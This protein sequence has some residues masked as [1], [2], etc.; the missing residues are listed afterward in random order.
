MRGS[1]LS[2]LVV[3]AVGFLLVAQA[4]AA[5]VFSADFDAG[6][7]A[8]PLWGQPAAASVQWDSSAYNSNPAGSG[9][10][11]L[12]DPNVMADPTNAA[13][14]VM[15][16]YG[17]CTGGTIHGTGASVVVSVNDANDIQLHPVRLL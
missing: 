2:V 3:V 14:Q 1:L 6:Y 17:D 8:G 4:G 15:Q 10:T 11:W 7:S 9:D 13:N 12:S 5:T 16:G